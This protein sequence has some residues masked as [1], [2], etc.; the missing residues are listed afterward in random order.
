MRLFVV[1]TFLFF[2]VWFKSAFAAPTTAETFKISPYIEAAEAIEAGDN[3]KLR[4]LVKQPGFD[5]NYE[6]PVIYFNPGRD[7]FTLL[8]WAIGLE[9]V[10]A[11]KILLEAGADP[12]KATHSET[13]PLM[14]ATSMKNDEIF[15]TLLVRYK[16]DT[17]R[18]GHGKVA[19]TI[20]LRRKL[21]TNRGILKIESFYRAELLVKHGAN[22][23][24]IF[25]RGKTPIIET[26]IQEQWHAVLWLLKHGAKFEARDQ[27]GHTMLCWLR[28]SYK[29]GALQ[30]SNL[31]DARD[32]V[33]DWLL[34]RGV[35]R[36]RIDPKLHPS[37]KCDD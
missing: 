3:T 4:K 11:V 14:T 1:G 12:N 24:I 16:A 17:N 8:D 9:Q 33:R 7:S 27:S 36:S 15:K 32:K 25:D 5:V 35:A 20:A 2:S 31:F 18:I 29:T 26:A 19:L 13:T 37:N 28:D 10:Q 23:N 30:P 21:T 22:V 6:T 34:A